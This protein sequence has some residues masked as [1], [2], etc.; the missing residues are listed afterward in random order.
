[1]RKPVIG[2]MP[3]VDEERE[4]IWMLPGYLDLIT[5]AGGLP[6]IL[7]LDLSP[8]DYENIKDSFDGFLFTGGH[9]VS[10]SMY[11]AEKKEYC[12]SP[13]PERDIMEKMIFTDAWNRD[14]PVFGICRGI[15][16]IN[17]MCQGSL[18]QDLE[19]EHCSNIE[20][21]MKPPYDRTV[22]NVIIRQDTPLHDI[23]K[24]E[25]KAVNSYHHQAVKELGKD[26]VPMAV[27]EDGLIEAVYA[28]SKKFIWAVQWHPELIFQKDDDQLSLVREFIKVC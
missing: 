10:P 6:L 5:E 18:Y 20:H 8:A 19:R 15:Q 12:G 2:V 4:S 3:L 23:W 1:M 28:P 26:L 24:K 21:H 27:S 22:H 17:V 25:K 7:P 16:F 11:G 9:D 13:S 14:V